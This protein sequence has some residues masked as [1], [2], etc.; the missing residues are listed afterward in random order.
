MSTLIAVKRFSSGGVLT[1][2]EAD[3]LAER[4]DAIVCPA[5]SELEPRGGLA[6]NIAILA[7][8]SVLAECRRIIMERGRVPV[9]AAVITKAGLLPLKGIIHCVGPRAGEDDVERKLVKAIH[10]ALQCAHEH[11]WSSLAIPAI[12]AGYF[13][14]APEMCAVT[15]IQTI[16][17]FFAL[18][19]GTRLTNVRLTL[20]PGPLAHCVKQELERL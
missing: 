14:V 1:A 11:G 19:P 18:Y 7:G 5:N 9:G 6:L 15:Y 2:V 17:E 4:T 3:I 16:R 20:M 10:A 8:P 13:R 12:S